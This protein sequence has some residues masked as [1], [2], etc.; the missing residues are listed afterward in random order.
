MSNELERMWKEVS[1]EYHE[2]A[3]RNLP[4]GTDE[5]CE[6]PQSRQPISWPRHERGTS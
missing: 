6:I 4:D 5:Y 1:V 3:S 2:A